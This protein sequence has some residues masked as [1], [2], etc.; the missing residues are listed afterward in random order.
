[1]EPVVLLLVIGTS[2]W[3]AVDAK[4]LGM[5]RGR[6]GGGMLDMSVTG[7]V[8]CCLLLWIIAFP[9]YLVA[10]GKYQALQ[11]NQENRFPMLAAEQ[12]AVAP[13]GANV[14]DPHGIQ[15]RTPPVAYAT[16]PAPPQMSPDGLWWWNGQQWVPVH[17]P[18]SHQHPSAAI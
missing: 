4:N 2:V 10:R 15:E 16:P 8:V 9:C 3:V 17:S 18:P 12:G 7:W 1:M 6:I 14:A 11:R 5:Q 13:F